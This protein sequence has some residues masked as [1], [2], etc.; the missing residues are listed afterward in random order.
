[1]PATARHLGMHLAGFEALEARQVLSASNPV[2][3]AGAMVSDVGTDVAF[4]RNLYQDLLGRTADAT[5]EAGWTAALESGQLSRREVAEAFLDSAEYRSGQLQDWYRQYLGR[6]LDPLGRDGWL[7]ACESGMTPQQ[8]LAGILRSSEY[9][10]LTGDT[11]AG[12]LLPAELG[13]AATEMDRDTVID[14]IDEMF[15]AEDFLVSLLDGT[16]AQPDLGWYDQYLGRDADTYGLQQ[17]LNQLAAG[18]SWDDVQASL[19][20]SDE[21]YEKAN[22]AA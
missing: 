2:A 15:L 3:E 21:Y 9:Q 8:V 22:S 7:A 17:W 16:E 20:A 10:N 13:A 6:D 5:G 18:Y 14:L 19:L 11:A 4:V 12:L 1:M